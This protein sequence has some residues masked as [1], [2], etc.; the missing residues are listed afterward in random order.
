MNANR[1]TA[2]QLAPAIKPTVVQIG[3]HW[4][5]SR[6][7]EE[8]AQVGH[9]IVA[10]LAQSERVEICCMGVATYGFLEGMYHALLSAYSADALN[11][12][13]YFASVP[14]RAMVN[15]IRYVGNL[16]KSQREVPT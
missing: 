16:V 3:G 4:Y 10:A 7:M 15:A 1:A 8:G 2:S 13:V 12:R 11:A 6:T 5:P 14:S 9:T